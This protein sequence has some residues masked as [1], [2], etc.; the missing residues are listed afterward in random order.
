MKTV[1]KPKEDIE[2]LINLHR[3]I[4]DKCKRLGY[5]E[6]R[7]ELC[8]LSVLVQRIKEDFKEYEKG[9]RIFHRQ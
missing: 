3:G 1:R 5:I 6:L 9:N 7:P 2:R 4:S 8:G